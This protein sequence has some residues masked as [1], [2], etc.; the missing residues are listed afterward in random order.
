MNS[1]A[2]IYFVTYIGLFILFFF[3]GHL[4]KESLPTN[5]NSF[6]SI[7]F[8][9]GAVLISGFVFGC[10]AGENKPEGKLLYA[11]RAVGVLINILS[12]L[13]IFII[14]VGGKKV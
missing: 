2:I 9:V 8:V 12:I 13:G 10:W 4:L 11:L 5:Q 7:G 3:L 14:L 1:K 6:L